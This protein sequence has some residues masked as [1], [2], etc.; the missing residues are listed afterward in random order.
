MANNHIN[1]HKC[2]YYY[3]TWEKK[4]AHGCRAMGFKSRIIPSMVVFKTS[5]DKC[6][7][8][9]LKKTNSKKITV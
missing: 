3:V 9:T 5:G 6:K 7:Y 8:Y 4:H 1:C 2:K